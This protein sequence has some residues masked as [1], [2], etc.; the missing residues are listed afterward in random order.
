MNLYNPLFTRKHP[1]WWNT[2]EKPGGEKISFG[3]NVRSG[4][5][6]NTQTNRIRGRHTFYYYEINVPSII[7]FNQS[8]IT[9]SRIV[10]NKNSKQEDEA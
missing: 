5:P 9:C 4:S 7:S 3:I 8:K 1:L 2:Y 6:N 10:K